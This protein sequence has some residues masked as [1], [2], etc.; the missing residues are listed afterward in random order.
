[1]KPRISRRAVTFTA[2][3][4]A[5][6]LAMSQRANAQDSASPVASP[7]VPGLIPDTPAGNQ[8][9]W[10]LAVVNGEAPIPDEAGIKQRFS[11]EVLS[12]VPAPALIDTFTELRAQF[13]PVAVVQILGIPTPLEINALVTSGDQTRFIVTVTVEQEPPHRMTGLLFSPYSEEM[14]EVPALAGWTE[15]DELLQSAGPAV[16]VLAATLEDNGGLEPIH[17]LNPE[18]VLAIGSAFKLY[19]LGAVAEA[20]EAGRLAWTDEIEVTDAVKSIPSGVTQNEISGTMLPVDEL[21]R[22]MI[23][24]SDNTATDM[25]MQAVG[26]EACEAALI[27]MGN[28]VPERNMPMITTREM[29]ILKYGEMDLLEAFASADEEERRHLLETRVSGAPLPS[30]AQAAARTNPIAIAT[31]E[32]FATMED[33]GRALIWLWDA[34]DRPG[35]APIKEIL[36]INAGYPVDEAVWPVVAFKGG[37]E[38]GV[39]ALAWYLE[40]ADGER[41][42]FAA[43]VNNPDAPL[44]EQDVIL[45]VIGAFNLLAEA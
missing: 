22:R 20:I 31:V 12:Q 2:G 11:G 38:I 36:T 33:L 26:R 44:P 42:V 16:S 6:L 27:T 29:S 17:S 40:R 24:I 43:A 23:S 4:G 34:S 25:L 13:A 8:L 5:L 41:F 15:L 37:S 45:S 35:L 19:V 3:A 14:P 30:L 1:M 10:V 28:S 32:W 9:A 18:T 39:L 7:A 21:A